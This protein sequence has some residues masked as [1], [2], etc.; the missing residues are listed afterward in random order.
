MRKIA[1]E[2]HFYLEGFPNPARD[3]VATAE[4][5]YWN[6]A[7]PRLPEFDALRLGAMD[8]AGIEISVLS[9]FA[10]G[11]HAERD[12]AKAVA[13]A[14]RG[15]DALAEQVARHPSRYRG[16]AMLAM[17]DGKA[18]ADELT[19]TVR[20]LGFK[21]AL[22]NGQTQGV[23]LDDA[24]YLPF[25]ERVA[26]LDVP[27]YLH[28]GD[29]MVLPAV[30][31]G[32]PGLGRSIWGWMGET[33]GHALRLVFSGLFDRLPGLSV[34]LGHMGEALPF[35]LW[36]IDS[37][38]G[39]YKPK[40]RLARKPSDYIRANFYATTAGNFAH[41]PLACT[42]ETLGEDRVMFS[43][44]YPLEDSAVAAR[45]IESAPVA[46]AVRAKICWDNAARVLRI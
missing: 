40:V 36:R 31:E 34:I 7:V 44:D 15:N 25:W 5:D 1:L 37:R 33:G 42:I 41:A 27:I 16:F 23:Y 4:P 24:R 28:P 46:E 26:E 22:I 18:A 35:L 14:K 43:V 11:T 2:E 20:E 19:R 3:N 17:Q 38:Y 12:A 29:P 39:I 13:A 30:Y 32:Y 6:Y 9:H 8:A 45:F 21:G 10:P